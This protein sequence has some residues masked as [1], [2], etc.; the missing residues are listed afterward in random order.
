MT[1]QNTDHCLIDPV[2]QMEVTRDKHVPGVTLGSV[3]YHFC[4]NSCRKAFMAD[5]DKYLKTKPLKPKGFWGRYLD[6]VKKATG[7]KPPCCH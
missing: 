3:I 5:P 2:C 4:A 7:G 1:A 6:K